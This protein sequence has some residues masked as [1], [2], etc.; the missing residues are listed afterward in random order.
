MPERFVEIIDDSGFASHIVHMLYR[1]VLGL[2]AVD[3]VNR[4]VHVRLAD[5]PL[6]SC[7]GGV[8]TIHGMVDLSWKAQRDSISYQVSTPEGYAVQLE[9]LSGK[10]L[11]LS[12]HR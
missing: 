3:S 8:P 1:N 4:R 5:V 12:R 2:W 11:T 7:A 9:N 10:K 6:T